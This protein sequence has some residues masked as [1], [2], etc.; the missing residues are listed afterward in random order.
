MVITFSHQ[1][2][3][4]TFSEWIVQWRNECNYIINWRSAFSLLFTFLFFQSILTLHS[5]GAISLKE[6]TTSMQWEYRWARLSPLFYEQIGS[7]KI[8]ILCDQIIICRDT[9][10]GPSSLP[11][12]GPWRTLWLTSGGWCQIMTSKMLSSWSSP[13][14]WPAKYVS[15]PSK[16]RMSHILKQFPMFCA[17][18][19]PPDS[20]W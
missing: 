9:E 13:H 19:F 4:W 14:L 10:Q 12:S 17:V 2:T 3:V 1:S 6:M 15:Y 5:C 11:P 8:L 16:L 20:A 18:W 7:L